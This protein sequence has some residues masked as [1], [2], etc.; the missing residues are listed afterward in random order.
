MEVEG[1]REEGNRV[2]PGGR[3][4]EGVITNSWDLEYAALLPERGWRE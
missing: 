2:P 3:T 1:G 4:G